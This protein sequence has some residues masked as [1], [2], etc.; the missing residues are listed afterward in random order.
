MVRTTGLI[1]GIPCSLCGKRMRHNYK[2][3]KF[4][5]CMDCAD[6]LCVSEIFENHP[7]YLLYIKNA[8]KKIKRRGKWV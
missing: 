4:S 6:E 1:I 2:I 7:K 8:I 3:G 5:I